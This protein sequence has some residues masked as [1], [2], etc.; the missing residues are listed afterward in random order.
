MKIF[1]RRINHATRVKEKASIAAFFPYLSRTRAESVIYFNKKIDITNV[2]TFL[3]E[4]KKEGVKISLFVLIVAAISKTFTE[5]PLLNRF[6]LGRRIYQRD[7]FD[8]SYVIKRNLTDE[9][10]EL[11]TTVAVTPDMSLK[12]IGAEMFRVAEELRQKEDDGLGDLMKLFGGLPRPVMKLLFAGIR[13][14]DY[15]GRVPEFIRKE[16]PFYCSVF[17]SNLGSIGVDAP[18]HHLYELGTTSIFLAIGKSQLTPVVNSK[19]GEVEV[20]RIVNL[21]FTADERICDGFYFARSIEKFLY[22]IENPH[23]I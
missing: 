6:V 14:L 13:F 19:T 18:F 8:V 2:T 16:L 9:G 7:V 5:R 15:H 1:N 4:K 10:E 23:T 17:I 22:Y 3:N 12:D 21:N 20:R 11:L